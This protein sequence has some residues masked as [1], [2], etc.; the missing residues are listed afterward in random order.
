M[1]FAELLRLALLS[2]QA[3]KLRSLL[4]LT[5]V[6]IAV[7]TMVAVISVVSG[8]NNYAASFVN[9]LGP[10]TIILAKFGLITS[11]EQFLR[12]AKRKDMTE[13]DV[14]AV[15]EG[16][17]LA[18]RVSG[19]VFAGHP[20][21]AEGRR[22]EG[23]FVV[24]AGTEFPMMIGLE[25]E[26]GRWYSDREFRSGAPVVV[27]GYDVKK[28]VFPNVD[29]IGRTVKVRGKPFRIIGIMAPQGSAFGQSRDTFVVMPTPAFE[30]AFGK[31]RSIDIFLEAKDDATREEMIDQ[32]RMVLRARM[33]TPFSAPDPFDVVDGE[34]L[35]ALWRN[36]TGLA[37]AL[38]ICISSVSLVVG[39]V[40]I[41]NTMF[42]SIVERTKEIGVRK[43]VGARRRDIRRQ[44]L[45]ESVLL[46]LL[47][48]MAGITLGFLVSWLVA[49]FSPFPAR[50]T[51]HLVVTALVVAVVAGLVAGWLPA[52]RVSRLD[53]VEALRAE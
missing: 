7:T 44:F 39:G 23:A 2:L 45:I 20:V 12:A 32:A 15:R 29:P 43:A 51:P 1:S 5:G 50:V 28:E 47:G 8:L 13:Q 24:G 3:H 11:R 35:L 10:N 40:A 19:R 37:F 46:S 17:T 31:N 42:A 38:V 18:R 21:Y 48:G 36:I 27:A 33:G 49:A 6:L 25:I 16:T 34:A 14:I 52:V 53:P 41:A 9:E 26:D 22:L 30:K 4:N